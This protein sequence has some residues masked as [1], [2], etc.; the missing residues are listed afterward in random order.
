MPKTFNTPEIRVH[1][2]DEEKFQIVEDIKNEAIKSGANVNDVDGV[3]ALTKDGWWL[4]RASNTEAA[5][6]VRCEATTAEGLERLK[7]TI[8]TML[9][10]RN[11]SV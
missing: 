2:K 7:E 4:V 1:V 11:I 10:A 9:K 5:L 3:R 8:F 6:V